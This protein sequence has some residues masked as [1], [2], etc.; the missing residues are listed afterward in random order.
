MK[1]KNIKGFTLVELLAVIVIIAIISAIAIGSYQIIRKRIN[2]TNYE[3]VKST[4]ELAAEKYASDTE[5]TVT[6]VDTLILLGYV[7]ADD[8]LGNIYDPRDN[9]TLNCYIVNI[10]EENGVFIATLG[11]K[12]V[13]ENNQCSS[14][15]MLTNNTLLCNNKNCGDWM[16][17]EGGGDLELKIKY[18]DDV[19]PSG[20]LSY[21][22]KSRSGVY[23]YGED[24][25]HSTYTINKPTVINTLY[26]V[27]IKTQ[28]TENGET[29]TK[30]YYA[31]SYVRIDNENPVVIS[32]SLNTTDWSSY[33]TLTVKAT[34]GNGSGISGYYFFSDTNNNSCTKDLAYSTSNTK[35]YDSTGTYVYCVKDNVDNV[36]KKQITIEKIDKNPPVYVSGGTLSNIGSDKIIY[37]DPEGNGAM[38]YYC[39]SS[40]ES[41]LDKSS[42]CF[43]NNGAF[44]SLSCGTTYYLYSYA[45]DSIGNSSQIKKH[46]N[47]TYYFTCSTNDHYP[48]S[49]GSSNNP[50]TCD[51]TCQMQ[52]NS[53]SWHDQQKIID[54]KTAT[55]AEKEAAKE[56]QEQLH[57]ENEDL[58]KDNPDCGTG[59][60]FDDGD[61]TWSDD[62]GD[63]LYPVTNNGTG[64]GST[65]S[66]SSGSGSSGSSG[67]TL[68]CYFGCS[69]SKHQTEC[70]DA[71][72]AAC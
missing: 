27:T 58:A 59:C 67:C 39:I 38:V 12:E 23:D 21:E 28:T 70:G 11:D 17:I 35:R 31:S 71:C 55:E 64:S 26:S 60:S 24:F 34:D 13:D 32:E 22:W 15:S 36:I 33:K 9:S 42:S 51:K 56:Q 5:S 18:N 54:S 52:Q 2:Q 1:K 53:E 37:N 72:D 3:N 4:I 29:K 41:I 10:K 43:K 65:G 45:E 30:T 66:G 69:T 62:N 49:G 6:N 19:I 8:E 50:S 61:G 25:S 47:T 46:S 20:I 68:S 63:Q 14:S 44:S 48:S 40:A 7:N 57:N 16:K